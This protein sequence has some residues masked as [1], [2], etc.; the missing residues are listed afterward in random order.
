MTFFL[1]KPGGFQGSALAGGDLEPSYA[2]VNFFHQSVSVDG[3]QHLS[4]IVFRALIELS[5][6]G[7]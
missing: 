5:F 6:E 1:R 4:D 2:C 7:K 3:K